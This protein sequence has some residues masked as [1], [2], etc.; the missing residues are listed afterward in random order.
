MLEALVKGLSHIGWRTKILSLSGLYILLI[1]AV[2][3]FGA[4]TIYQ[5]NLGMEDMVNKAQPRV[6]LATNA[7]IAVVELEIGRAHV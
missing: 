4:Y 7:R 2:G 1:L 3:L 6:D 5:Q